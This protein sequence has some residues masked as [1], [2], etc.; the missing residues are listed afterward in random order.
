MPNTSS[1]E[2]KGEWMTTSAGE[3]VSGAGT[4]RFT[5]ENVEQAG[6]F[7][8]ERI[9]EVNKDSKAAFKTI[10]ARSSLHCDSQTPASQGITI[11]GGSEGFY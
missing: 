5:R 10:E 8:R 11:D 4:P 2:D 3:S 1:L 9:N 7:L 6:E